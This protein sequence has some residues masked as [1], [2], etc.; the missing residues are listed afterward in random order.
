MNRAHVPRKRFGQHFLADANYIRRIIE[1][2]APKFSDS[3]VEIG[4]GLGALTVPLLEY[5]RPLH[6]IELDRD[7]AAQLRDRFPA[8]DLTVHAADALRFDFAMLPTPLR[9]VGNLPYNISTPLLFHLA[10]YR[11]QVRD[12]HLML[13][14]EVVDRMTAE[15]STPDY[16]RLTV[17]LRS[18]FDM[19]RLFTIPP[20]AFQPPP[21][22]NSAVVRM[23]PLTRLPHP[24]IAAPLFAT[25][26]TRAFGQRRKTLRNA[27]R[28]VASPA[29]FEVAGVDP[30]LRAENLDVLAFARLAAALGCEREVK[31]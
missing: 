26:V 16:G 7:L 22:V 28:D 29:D 3:V 27:L 15:P 9:V 4:P 21:K 10:Q 17:M 19:R 20:G 25:V 30:T 11:A 2:V 6:V 5:V 13:Q 18:C 8:T 12:M 31:E 23:V 24:A 1:A 14:K